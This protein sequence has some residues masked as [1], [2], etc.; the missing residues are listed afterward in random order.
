MDWTTLLGGMAA[1]GATALTGG[2]A[3]PLLAGE[4]AATGVGAGAAAGVGEAAA[5]GAT[6]AG[7]AAAGTGLADAA[8]AATPAAVAAPAP[9]AGNALGMMGT[10]AP[11]GWSSILQPLDLGPAAPGTMPGIAAPS[12]APQ[13]SIGDALGT[14]LTNTGGLGGPING[15]AGSVPGMEMQG[16]LGAGVTGQPAT[17]LMGNLG[18]TAP[19]GIAPK[20]PGFTTQQM[21]QLAK[22][23]GGD[24]PQG[25]APAPPGGT[26]A[27]ARA[28]PNLQMQALSAPAQQ[29]RKSLAQ[30]LAGR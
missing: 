28:N 29:G 25:R 3:A 30:I 17:G 16:G 7:E 19:G 10:S 15:A 9:V 8:L 24:Q 2:T 11:S 4:A 26:S 22:L 14:G 18:S 12:L 20:T 13:A 21:A 27:G 1:L 23:A 5:V 6:G